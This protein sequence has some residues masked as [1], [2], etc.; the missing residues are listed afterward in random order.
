M[1]CSLTLTA[2]EKNE[3]TEHPE[4]IYIVWPDMKLQIK[5]PHEKERSG[6]AN[7]LFRDSVSGKIYL[8]DS[9]KNNPHY[10]SNIFA[11][12]SIAHIKDA[13]YYTPFEQGRYDV[14]ILY[15]SG[16]YIRQ[17][18]I[19]F[20]KDADKV[21]DLRK[22]PIQLADKESQ[23]WLALRK[24]NTIIGERTLNHTFSDK[25]ISGYLFEQ[26]SREALSGIPIAYHTENNK[27]KSVNSAYD[28]YFETDINDKDIKPTLEIN[29]IG[30]EPRKIDVKANSIYFIV[31]K[32]IV[33][34]EKELT[35]ITTG[36]L[37]KK[38]K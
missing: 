19:L 8:L 21:I 35:N 22:D 6:V 5:L 9:V 15:N 4:A 34:S 12:R 33:L 36:P 2:Q 11:W 16:K 26:Q 31:L 25:K 1:L 23:N 38:S 18:N 32:S 37:I 17:E 30:S 24:Y 27:V 28:G 10:Q 14:I 13:R 29:F 20:K 7:L 3:P